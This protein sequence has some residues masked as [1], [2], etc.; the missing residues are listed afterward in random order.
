MPTWLL[1]PRREKLKPSSHQMV[2][3]LKGQDEYYYYALATAKS[4][5]L[6]P[7]TND[8][9]VLPLLTEDLPGIGGVIKTRH[10]DFI[11]EESPAYEPSGEGTHV[12][13]LIEKR[14]ITTIHA[15]SRIAK[16]LKMGRKY[17]GFAGLKDTHAVAR[18][19]ISIEHINPDSLL[20]LQLPGVKVLRLARHRNKILLGHL[21]ANSF[22][23]RIRNFT[24]P[25]QQAVRQTEEMLAVLT[26]RGVPNFFGPQRFGNRNDGHLLG[27]A[28]I[29]GQIE[30]F[31]DIFLGRPEQ[32]EPAVFVTARTLYEKG[33]YQKAYDSWPNSFFE[34]RHALEQLLNNPA[35]KK[36]AYNAI[37]KHL[38]RLYISA[39]QSHIFN[40][41]LTARMPLIDKLIEGDMAYKHENGACFRVENP[42][43]EQ[44]RCD[45]F[46]I[47]PTGPI[48][49]RRMTELTGPAGAIENPMLTEV[50]ELTD[51][52]N[53]L[54]KP[55]TG[56]SRRPLRFRPKNTKVSAGQDDLGD[57]IELQF[58]LHSG[59]YATTLLREIT[60]SKT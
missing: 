52:F 24:P 4:V 50:R 18:Q 46:E 42:Q 32:C 16:A 1:L 55:T 56:G 27:K 10:E 5:T 11:V 28:I 35:G 8:K 17:I 39:Y 25:P 49:G 20:Q 40:R 57:Y 36:K 6:M 9:L 15:L 58:S 38:R 29:T 7:N 54:G 21:S 48:F 26:R 47:S 12:Y 3:S 2:L 13:A 51:N 41:T 23:I 34:Q 37:D 43:A 22:T 30:Q 14:G 44:P 33:D 31:L 45:A 60:K 53:S 19:W 59:C